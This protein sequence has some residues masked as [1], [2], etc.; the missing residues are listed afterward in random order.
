MRTRCVDA[1]H[2]LSLYSLDPMMSVAE[3]PPLVNSCKSSKVESTEHEKS[4]DDP[5]PHSNPPTTTKN[6]T[7]KT[8]A[9]DKFKL[10]ARIVKKNMTLTKGLAQEAEKHLKIYAVPSTEEKESELFTFNVQSFFPECQSISGLSMRVKMILLKV[11][12]SRT[13]EEL[14]I[15]RRFVMK[16]PCFSRYSLYVRQELA[17]VLYYE[18]FEKG[19][20]VIRQ[21]D[22]GYSFYF[23]VSGSVLVE[24]QDKDPIHDTIRN[25]I[26]GELGA[27]STFGDLALLNNDVRRATIVCK[28]NCEFLKVD[29]IDFNKILMQSCKENW[30]HCESILSRHQIFQDWSKESLKLAVEGSQFVEF[31]ANSVVLRD[32]SQPS[33]HVFIV[34]KGKCQVVQKVS[35]LLQKGRKREGNRQLLSSQLTLPPIVTDKTIQWQKQQPSPHGKKVIKKW[36][37]IRTLCPGDYFGIGEGPVDTSVICMDMAECLLVNCIVLAKQS[38]G[39]Y[40]ERLRKETSRL[41]PST[42]AAFKSYIEGKQWLEYKQSVLQEVIS[43]L[44]RHKKAHT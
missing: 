26:V 18:A 8:T 17:H 1:L 32:L 12:W 27:G 39:R 33:D 30:S 29:K 11:A 37:L 9:L 22:T 44:R 43:N 31:T 41:Y 35:L 14:T 20:V 2:T 15:V 16:L 28:E 36:W 5:A 6:D 21:G 34:T 19:R 7:V 40:L 13:E 23:I 3:L 42:E 38:Q 25:S 4:A 24:I 10:T